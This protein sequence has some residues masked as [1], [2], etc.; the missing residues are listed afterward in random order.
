MNYQEVMSYLDNAKVFGSVLGLNTMR[1]LLAELNDPQKELAAVHVAGTN[2]KGS[3]AA[4]VAEILHEAGY[5]TGLYISPFIQRFNERVQVDGITITEDEIAA[6]MTEVVGAARAV[7][8]RGI[9]PPTVFELITAMGFLYFRARRCDIVVV[10]VGLGGR[11]DATN[12]IDKPE[13]AVITHIGLDHTEQLGDTISKIAGE[14]G[15]IIKRGC[16]VVL[17]RQ[18]PSNGAHF[19]YLQKP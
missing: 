4:Y 8:A 9:Q 2:G 14:K 7:T 18:A 17:Y 13:A 10:E 12:V 16:E 6:Y 15:G 3:T 1:A 5:R 11:L 19:R